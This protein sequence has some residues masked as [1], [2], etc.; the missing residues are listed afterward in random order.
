M[1]KSFAVA[2]VT[3][4][5]AANAFATYIVVLRTGSTYKAK[6]RPVVQNGKTLIA[7]ESGQSLSL[8]ASLVDFAKSDQM[9][10][11]GMGDTKV[12]AVQETAPAP[13]TPQR[14]TLGSAF[15]I[16]KNVGGNAPP[17]PEP[18]AAPTA[19]IASPSGSGVSQEVIDKFQRAYENVGLFEYKVTPDG[20]GKI[21][22]ELTADSEDKVFNAISATA[23][24][25]SKDAGVPGANIQMVELFMKT[26]MGGSSG[27]FQMTKADAVDLEA[28]ATSPQVWQDYFV[29][30]VIF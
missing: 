3:A 7:L 24:L 4:L 19:A 16:R 18:A 17:V 15:H 21:H 6:A 11:A 22:V 9:T 23:F 26:T 27:R 5:F 14:S 30:K 2:A 13:T 25:I 12:L 20:S 8:D 28:K 29:R 10:N 1:K